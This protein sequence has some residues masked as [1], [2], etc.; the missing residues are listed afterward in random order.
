M[1][2]L[3]AVKLAER[4]NGR[5]VM[6]EISPDEAAAIKMAGLVVVYGYSDDCLELEGAI[7]DETGCFGGGT[8]Y[9]SKDGVLQ[10]PDCNSDDCPYFAVAKRAAKAI[11]AVWHDDGGP[12]WTF[13]TDIPHKTFN[14]NEDG[15]V[16]CRGIVFSVE[17]L[18]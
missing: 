3:T 1:E 9:V 10:V 4:L 6:H 16:W 8:I 17:D 2:N 15:V 18:V 11:K 14:I 5:E 12:C 13:E 7:S